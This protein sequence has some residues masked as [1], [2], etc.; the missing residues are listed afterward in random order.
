MEQEQPET[1][2]F[3]VDTEATEEVEKSD[4]KELNELIKYIKS[5]L[6]QID[7]NESKKDKYFG[8]HIKFPL[9]NIQNRNS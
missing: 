8:K 6:F 7:P 4:N 2:S 9:M 5:S 1:N 3:F